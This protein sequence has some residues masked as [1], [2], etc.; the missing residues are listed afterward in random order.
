MDI[1]FSLIAGS[2]IVQTKIKGEKIMKDQSQIVIIGGGIFGT[3]VAYHLAK[4]GCTDVILLEKGELTSGS[5]WHAA[6]LVGQLRSD[7]NLTR[8]LQYSV[9]L[10]GRLE[11]ETGLNTGWNPCGCLH[12]AS[13]KE[14]MYELKKGA[15]T[16]RRPER[17]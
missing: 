6:G 14:R 16:A 1:I 4:A 11:E 7:R 15:T 5:T 9:S 12:L 8:M 2:V 3:S 13:T 10:Y 17:D